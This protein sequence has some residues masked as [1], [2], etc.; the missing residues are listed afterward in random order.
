MGTNVALESVKD[1]VDKIKINFVDALNLRIILDKSPNVP[2]KSLHP[3]LAM[4]V[5]VKL[6]AR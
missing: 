5:L 2:L 3:F 1:I 6:E 4:N